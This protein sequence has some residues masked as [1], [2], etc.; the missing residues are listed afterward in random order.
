[1]SWRTTQSPCDPACTQ[2]YHQDYTTSLCRG[3]PGQG[4]HQNQSPNT[5]CYS[6]DP[7]DQHRFPPPSHST[8]QLL[9]SNGHLHPH[10]GK[11]RVI[12]QGLDPGSLLVS[13]GLGSS[14]VSLV[15]LS[16]VHQASRPVDAWAESM[17]KQSSRIQGSILI[18]FLIKVNQRGFSSNKCVVV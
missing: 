3:S 13:L 8:H 1:M 14:L 6:I 9:V 15:L 12:P 4:A 2:Q 5:L 18:S 17:F 11:V 16:S 10:Q 7:I